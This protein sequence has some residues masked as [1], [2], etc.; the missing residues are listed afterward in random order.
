MNKILAQDNNSKD[1]EREKEMQVRICVTRKELP[2]LLGCG[3]QAADRVARD[4]KATIRV[5]KRILI[6]IKKLEEYIQESA[7]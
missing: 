1:V 6:S 5:G 7:E 4:A 2:A 3:Q